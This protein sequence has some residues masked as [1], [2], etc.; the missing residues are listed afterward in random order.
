VQFIIDANLPRTLCELC[1]E[2]GHEAVHARDV[3][4]SDSPDDAIA[5]FAREHELA[6]LTTDF[7]FS[8]IRKFPPRAHHGIVVFALPRRPNRQKIHAFI[9]KFL[10]DL[11]EAPQGRLLIVDEERIRIR[12]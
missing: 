5:A 3:G 2:L 12:E 6:I 9:R 8:D 4:L 1:R 10:V 11:S 7:D